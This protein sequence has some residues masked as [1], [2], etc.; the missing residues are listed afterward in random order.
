MLRRGNRFDELV[1]RQLELFAVDEPDLLAEADAAED[2]WN[3][4]PRDEAEEAYGDYQLAVDAIADRLLEIREGYATT[5]DETAAEAYRTSFNRRSARRFRR[6]PTIA[7][8][9]EA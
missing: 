6:H 8:D 5:L 2:A 7:S 4:A 1:E 9:L 3:R